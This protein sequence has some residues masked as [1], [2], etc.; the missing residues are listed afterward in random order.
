MGKNESNFV[1]VD[2]SNFVRVD[3]SNFVRVDESNFVRVNESKVNTL[4]GDWPRGAIV[5]L[6]L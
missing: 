1:R 4:V 6:Q 3:E 5:E 2:E